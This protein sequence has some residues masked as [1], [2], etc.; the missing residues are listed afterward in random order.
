[1]HLTV[2]ENVEIPLLTTD[3]PRREI[4]ERA[5]DQLANV[6][7]RLI[8]KKDRS[9]VQLSG[10][11][12][13]RVAIARALVNNPE[14][15]MADEPVAQLERET[16]DK[17]LDLFKELNTKGDK[18]IVIVTTDERLFKETKNVVT[19]EVRIEGGEIQKIN[20]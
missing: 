2:Q 7:P 10:G 11:E 17:I 14:I 9:P 8:E 13:Q 6:D 18:T 16:A 12:K 1:D 15:I 3:I 4:R 20:E 5:F 19:K